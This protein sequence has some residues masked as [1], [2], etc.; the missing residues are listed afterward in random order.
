[1]I[2]P[3][4]IFSRSS[5]QPL[6][7][8]WEQLERAVNAAYPQ[9]RSHDVRGEFAAI[10]NAWSTL[11]QQNSETIDVFHKKKTQRQSHE[12]ACLSRVHETYNDFIKVYNAQRRAG[13]I[14][15]DGLSTAAPED[16]ALHP[17]APAPTSDLIE[18]ALVL[19]QF[20]RQYWASAIA[21]LHYAREALNLQDS[22]KTLAVIAQ[23]IEDRY[24][25][26]LLHRA[27]QQ[28]LELLVIGGSA[29]ELQ[30][31]REQLAAPYISGIYNCGTFLNSPM[32]SDRQHP[33]A[34]QF[35][36]VFVRA[37]SH[38]RSDPDSVENSTL[39][40]GLGLD[41]SN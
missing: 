31:A 1:M 39:D 19:A 35:H 5:L 7:T 40:L 38:P 4:A 15:L 36:T 29:A 11:A 17:G 37:L 16:I 32:G 3:Q 26:P 21:F 18:H 2:V 41:M 33:M 22:G 23:T 20:H 9:P 13:A 28:W 8:I 14:A 6:L 27:T 34:A 24:F 30:V 25:T 10:A 12:T